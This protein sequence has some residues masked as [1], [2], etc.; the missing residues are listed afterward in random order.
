MPTILV[1]EDEAIVMRLLRKMLKEYALVEAATAEEAVSRFRNHGHI[2]LVIADVSLPSSSGVQ[3]ALR[4]RSENPEVPVILT[5]GYP[6]SGW[7]KQDS[8]DLAQLGP[9][10]VKVLQKPFPSQ[11]LR[12]TVRELTGPDGTTTA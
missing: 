8:T 5:S 10:G 7:N 1:L 2:D 9:S 11:V 4:M 6:V 12:E 3:A